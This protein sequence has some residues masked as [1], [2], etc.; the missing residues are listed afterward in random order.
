MY[1]VFF[2]EFSTFW[3]FSPPP[4]PPFTSFISV[5]Y[6]YCSEL[7]LSNFESTEILSIKARSEYTN[8]Q[9]SLHLTEGMAVG[10]P[11]NFLQLRQ[12]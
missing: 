11:T 5:L 4:L 8:I 2:T 10:K 3:S 7:F 6:L 9:L 1:I 12:K